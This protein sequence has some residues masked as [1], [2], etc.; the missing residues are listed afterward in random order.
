MHAPALIQRD[1]PAG[2]E[3][4]SSVLRRGFAW[5]DQSRR[6]RGVL[7]MFVS[8]LQSRFFFL[9]FGALLASLC[10]VTIS[11]DACH[12]FLPLHPSTKFGALSRLSAA[13]LSLRQPSLVSHGLRRCVVNRARCA[14]RPWP[15]KTMAELKSN[16]GPRL[17][18]PNVS[19]RKPASGRA[20]RRDRSPSSLCTT[21]DSC[22]LSALAFLTVSY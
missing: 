8:L 12:H 9:V 10:K 18:T 4:D 5:L 22:T 21:R 11:V 16:G 2:L 1:F 15:E 6:Y 3:L 14:V 17:V 7:R 13:L 20:L 19:I